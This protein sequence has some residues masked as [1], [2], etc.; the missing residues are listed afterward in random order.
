M[1]AADKRLVLAHWWLSFALFVCALFLGFWQFWFRS[2][3]PPGFGTPTQYYISVTAHGTIIA[4]A[5]TTL[6]A[7]GLGYAVTAL[8]TGAAL[9]WRTGAWQA[10]ALACIGLALLL[11]AI[12][13]GRATVLYTFYPPLVASFAFY[14]GLTL[15]VVGSWF[16]VAHTIASFYAWKGAHR[17]QTTPLGLFMVTATAMLWLWASIGAALELLFQLIPL[18]LGWTDRIDVGL[19]RT[20]FSWTLHAIVYFW[21]LPA[22]IA[23]YLIV[24][25]EAGGRLYSD[26]MGRLAFVL[27]L[28]FGVPVGLHHLFMD[29]EHGTAFKF[30]QGVFTVFVSLPTLLTVFSI[31]ASLEIA[32]RLRGGRGS[33]GWVTTLPWGRPAILATGLAAIMLGLGGLGGL[34]NMSYALNSAV[35]NTAWITAHFHLIFGGTVVILYFAIAYHLWPTLTGRSLHSVRSVRVQLVTWCV[36]MLLLTLPW[37]VTGIMGQPRRMAFFDY[38]DAV[39]APTA[40]LTTLSLLGGTLVLISGLHFLWNLSLA[41]SSEMQQVDVRFARPAVSNAHVP[42]ALNGFALW[43]WL[44]AAAMVAV[45][46]WPIAQFFIYPS[47]GAAG[48]SV[49]GP[50]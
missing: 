7:M 24:P 22:Y 35:H 31:C 36:G 20:L 38:T 50:P 4:F 42:S 26:P 16:W 6:F 34:I 18:S 30:V 9:R 43:N 47:F 8:T 44:T 2:P 1:T 19:A 29:P 32:G 13:S 3:I 21:L 27:F 46:G 14:L 25:E 45:Y 11:V 12:V 23:L 40:W 37:H 17:G 39:L 28:V 15:L 5:F 48:I 49:G 10:F 33:L 41:R